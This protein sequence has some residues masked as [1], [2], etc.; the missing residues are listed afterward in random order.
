MRKL[1][2][3]SVVGLSLAATTANAELLRTRLRARERA[4]S[5]ERDAVTQ[6]LD[7]IS[8]R[9]TVPELPSPTVIYGGAAPSYAEPTLVPQVESLPPIPSTEAAPASV[10]AT[11][12]QVLPALYTNVRVRD[13]RNIPE[14]AVPCI[15]SAPDP[16]NPCCNVSV[17][18]CAPPCA[19]ADV[20]CRREGE[21][22]V[23]DFGKCEVEVTARRDFV[24]V[25]Y[26]R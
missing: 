13:A 7:R 20:K 1:M 11:P 23:Y 26:D 8:Y 25:D 14:C 4:A 22:I 5:A 3:M 18:I 6:V 15:V 9:E 19:V 2:V 12:V 16:C 24:V 10:V 21:K 17:Q